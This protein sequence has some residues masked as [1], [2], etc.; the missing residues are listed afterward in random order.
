MRT[1][2]LGNVHVIAEQVRPGEVDM[3]DVIAA[4]EVLR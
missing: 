3:S 2:F 4:G 1:S